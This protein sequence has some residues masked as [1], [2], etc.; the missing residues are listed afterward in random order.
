MADLMDTR[1]PGLNTSICCRGT[2]DRQQKSQR[3]D[4]CRVF[5]S[6][7]THS[8]RC[9]EEQVHKTSMITVLQLVGHFAIDDVSIL[10][11]QLA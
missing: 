7:V 6:V 1:W 3:D 9:K 4:W 5:A 10:I 2:T 8:S 11:A